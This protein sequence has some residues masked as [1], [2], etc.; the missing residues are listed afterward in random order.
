MALAFLWGFIAAASLLV[1]AVI[2]IRG[3]PGP[4]LV[5][6]VM[7]FGA[8]VLISALAYELIAKAVAVEG[9]LGGVTVGLFA[10]CAVYAFGDLLLARWAHTPVT[11]AGRVPAGRSTENDEAEGGL[12]IAL[13]ALLDG[14]PENAALGLTILQG[15]SVSVAMLAAVFVSNLPEAIAATSSLRGAGW[16]DR[17]VLALWT[18]V[19]IACGL[20]SGLGYV[21]LDGAS[22]S[23]LAFV[24][25]FAAG[26]ILTML[27]TSLIPGAYRLAGREAGPIT[28]VGFGVAFALTWIA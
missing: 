11:G 8:G 2:A 13:G 7:A 9:D 21:L 5:G 6:L 3:A 24:F 14:I 20:S 16:T 26:A 27:S 17:K 25:A 22:P 19:V 4:K 23:V 12:S 1:G 15:G 18:G 28:V 10:G